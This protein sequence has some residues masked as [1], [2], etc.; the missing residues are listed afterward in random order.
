MSSSPAI[1]SSSNIGSLAKYIFTAFIVFRDAAQSTQY[2]SSVL[3]IM[4]ALTAFC[5]V[6]NDQDKASNLQRQGNLLSLPCPRTSSLS[7]LSPRAS[8]APA[9]R[10]LLKSSSHHAGDQLETWY[11]FSNGSQMCIFWFRRVT[12]LATAMRVLMR[13]GSSV[14]R[15][16]WQFMRAISPRVRVC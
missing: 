14:R 16:A 3:H 10:A 15:M 8:L 9:S 11:D 2:P 4:V 13:L 6:M 1:R 12:S 7:P 5:L